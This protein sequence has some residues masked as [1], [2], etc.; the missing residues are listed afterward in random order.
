MSSL[1]LYRKALPPWGRVGW[2]HEWEIHPSLTVRTAA[3]L[4]RSPTLTLPHGRVMHI[5]RAR[6]DELPPPRRGRVGV[7]VTLEKAAE[8][9]P[10][11]GWTRLPASAQAIG[12]ASTPRP[13]HPNPPPPRGRE[14]A[15]RVTGRGK[16]VRSEAGVAK[17]PHALRGQGQLGGEGLAPVLAEGV[18]DR[19]GDGRRH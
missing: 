2:G 8:R 11:S 9:A 13:P 1:P 15:S 18:V 14:F 6:R 4:E 5:G 12:R 3:V 16:P 17:R 7:G 10:L 19:A